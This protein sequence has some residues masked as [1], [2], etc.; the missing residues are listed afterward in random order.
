MAKIKNKKKAKKLHVTYNQKKFLA[1]ESIRSMAA[2]HAKILS[3]GTAILRVSDC[4]T[5]V[6]IWNDFNSKEG[7]LEMIEKL[8]VLIEQLFEFKK[9]VISR[10]HK[11]IFT[12]TEIQEVEYE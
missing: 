5:S 7:K 4:N 11:N 10:C 1:P 12:P 2:V 8:D 6:R 3:D 9:E